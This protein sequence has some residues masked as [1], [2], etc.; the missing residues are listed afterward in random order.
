[1]LGKMIAEETAMLLVSDIAFTQRSI[2][3]LFSDG[4]SVDLLVEIL[5]S[6][7]EAINDI[8][9]ISVVKYK[10]SYY[11]LDNRRLYCFK[12]A[13]ISSILVKITKR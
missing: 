9:T 2:S 13:S 12:R 5:E 3:S 6:D 1:M 4:K 11:S 10:D 7:S 8:P